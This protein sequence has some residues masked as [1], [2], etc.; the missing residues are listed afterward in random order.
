MK[1]LSKILKNYLHNRT[2]ASFISFL[3]SC[4][5]VRSL[6]K[7]VAQISDL[8]I[9]LLRRSPAHCLRSPLRKL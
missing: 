9:Q 5:K 2:L 1:T 8:N 3:N 6:K 4:V 7:S